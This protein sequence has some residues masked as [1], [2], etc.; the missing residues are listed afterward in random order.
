MNILKGK[1]GIFLTLTLVFLAC[2][3]LL[4]KIF[5]NTSFESINKKAEKTLCKKE[6]DISRIM[7]QTMRNYKKRGTVNLSFKGLFRDKGFILLIYENDTIKFWSGNRPC[8]PDT[9]IHSDLEKPFAKLGNGW[10]EIRKKKEGSITVAGLILTF[11]DYR[12]ENDFLV[13]GFQKDFS[14]CENAGISTIKSQYP[15]YSKEKHFL[16]SMIFNGAR[17]KG[18]VLEYLLIVLYLLCFMFFMAFLFRCYKNISFLSSKP[19]LI[20]L[21]YTIDVF[22]IRGLLFYFKIPAAL[23]ETVLFSPASYALSLLLPSLGDMLFNVLIISYI[24]FLVYKYIKEPQPDCKMPDRLRCFLAFFAFIIIILL[25]YSV[26]YF[27]KSLIFDSSIPLSLNNIFSLNELS[28]ILFFII[29]TIILSFVLAAIKL[30]EILYMG[31]N[32]TK[33]YI[34]I[35]ALAL[36]TGGTL[37]LYTGL[38]DLIPYLLLV[39]FIFSFLIIRKKTGKMISYSLI[40]IYIV[41]FT[42]LTTYILNTSSDSKE[43]EKR[44]SIIMAIAE[45][46]DPIAEFLFRDIENKTRNDSA[47]NRMLDST[48][49][50]ET[51]IIAYLQKVYF[52]G[53]WRKYRIQ[54]TICHNEQKLLVNPYYLSVG[55]DSYFSDKI[56][57]NGEQTISKNFYFLNYGYTSYVGKLMLGNNTGEKKSVNVYIELDI[58]TFS[59]DLGYPELLIDKNMD[60]NPDLGNYSYARYDNGILVKK[61]GKYEYSSVFKPGNSAEEMRFIKSDNYEHLI[62]KAPKGSVY[63]LSKKNDDFLTAISPFSYMLIF[64]SLYVVF[65]IGIMRFSPKMSFTGMSYSIRLQLSVISIVL[66]SFVGIGTATVIYIFN[67]NKNKNTDLLSEK[68][69]SLLIELKSKLGEETNINPTSQTVENI[70]NMLVKFSN[71]FFTD[72]NIYG[73]NGKL[74]ASSRPEIFEEELISERM[75]SSAYSQLINDKKLLFIQEENIGKQR[76][77]SAYA[78]FENYYGETIAYLNLPYFAKQNVIRKEISGFLMAYTN[79]YIL[80]IALIIIITLIISNYITYPLQLISENIKRI[81]LGKKNEKISWSKKEEIGNL[82]HEYNRMIDELEKSAVLL[83]QSERESAWRDMAKQVAHEIKNPLTPMKLSIQHL[84]KAW[85]QKVPDMDK[86]IKKIT[87]TLI[88]QI[89]SLSAIATEFSDFAKMPSAR[90]D[91]ID[92]TELIHA[93]AQM[94][95]DLPNISISLPEKDKSFYIF[96]DR[97]QILRV[98]NNLFSNSVEAIGNKEDGRIELSLKTENNMHLLRLSDNGIGIDE[99]QK[100]FIFTPDFTTKTAGTGLG[101]T[102]VRSIII[103]AGGEIRFESEKGEGTVFFIRFSMYRDEE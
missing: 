33:A 73:I 74:I 65:F 29:A 81:K 61:T 44:K 51:D 93:A 76:Y 78:P 70:Q 12:Y 67:I 38:K 28:I 9:Y 56:E 49:V 42:I 86:R 69:R 55:C 31:L 63:V 17:E 36:I 79:F 5:V 35:S 95:C 16:F 14:G 85:E 64:F 88:E 20:V 75:N 59:G 10:F 40:I 94:Y 21:I 90:Q 27:I 99:N 87:K 30:M 11:S 45:E 15:V 41:I 13:N 50:N 83:A 92:L 96:A 18:K 54:F 101:L 4:N 6:E 3:I 91:K 37:L 80:L 23:Y 84:E 100:K 43:K 62:Y 48:T 34:I 77:L 82:I 24:F 58:K 47:L 57:T 97:K 32:N 98:F 72:I 7:D 53:F 71:I 8:I 68:T 2:A 25:F 1:S 102:M 39:I 103:E 19:G 52:N 22:I 60:I 89:E 66:I 46:R 26:I